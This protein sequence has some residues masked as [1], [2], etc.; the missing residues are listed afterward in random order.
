[1]VHLMTRSK[2]TVNFT[3]HLIFSLWLTRNFRRLLRNTLP[4]E[5]ADSLLNQL[6][7]LLLVQLRNMGLRRQLNLPA[8]RWTL[9]LINTTL[10]I[11]QRQLFWRQKSKPS[12]KRS[13]L[14][15]GAWMK[16]GEILIW[17]GKGRS[18]QVTS[19]PLLHVVNLLLAVARTRSRSILRKMMR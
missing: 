3:L 13:T 1:M 17:R 15:L 12:I 11:L 4:L 14:N 18:R 6:S 10:S 7:N 2:F 19:L 9:G 16:L 8:L 5:S